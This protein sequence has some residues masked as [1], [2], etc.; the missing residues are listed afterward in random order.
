MLAE[1]HKQPKEVVRSL[2]VVQWPKLHI[3]RCQ[4]RSWSCLSCH[5]AFEDVCRPLLTY[6]DRMHAFVQDKNSRGCR[7]CL[8]FGGGTKQHGDTATR[9]LNPTQPKRPSKEVYSTLP[10]REILNAMEQAQC[11]LVP[12]QVWTDT[13]TIIRESFVVKK[14]L[15][16]SKSTKIKHTKYFWHT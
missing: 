15:Y 9:S 12:S 6:R 7:C 4:R 11:L 3:N 5:T 2:V 10:S 8:S 1:I 14:F 16:P 13:T